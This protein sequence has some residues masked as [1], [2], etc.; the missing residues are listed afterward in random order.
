MKFYE[1]NESK[2][3]LGLRFGGSE[4]TEEL[5]LCCFS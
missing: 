3:D 2:V 4:V 5:Y 1:E